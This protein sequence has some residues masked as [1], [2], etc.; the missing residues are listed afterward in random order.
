MSAFRDETR[1]DR[2]EMNKQ[3]AYLAK[4]LGTLE[5]DLIAPAVRPVIAKY[6]GCEPSALSV[7]NLRRKDGEDFE[8]DLLVSCDDMV[9]MIEVKASPRPEHV[10]EIIDKATLFPDFYPEHA[11]RKVVPMFGSILF[12][13]NVLKSASRKGVYAVA[14]REWDYVDILNFD[15]VKGRKGR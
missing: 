13:E 11:G 9:F 1:Q 6:F 15:T 8:V 2:R 14:Y 7:R 4:K 3:W 10:R 12:P 5:E